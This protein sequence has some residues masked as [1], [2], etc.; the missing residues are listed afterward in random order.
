M[1]A[2]IG[3]DLTRPRIFFVLICAVLLVAQAAWADG[4]RLTEAQLLRLSPKADKS[5]AAAIVRH[6][7]ELLAAGI[8]GE[9]R[10]SHFLAQVLT[11]TAGLRRLDE[12]LSYSAERLVEVFRIPPDVAQGLA[13]RPRETANYL[14]GPRLGNLGR[15]TDDGWIYRGSGFIQLTGRYNFRMRGR[16]ARLPLEDQ[17]DLARQ[18]REGL[19]AAT[20]YWTA[21][22]INA[23]A[24]A[25]D[26]R[27]VR[28]RV[29][30]AL[31]GYEASLLWLR[32]SRAVLT[33]AGGRETALDSGQLV[34]AA[35]E[36][37][38]VLRELG[39]LPPS[40]TESVP[41]ERVE[42]AL[43][44]FQRSRSL[45]ETGAV[46][47]DTFYALTDPSEW[48]NRETRRAGL[49]ASPAGPS[50]EGISFDLASRQARAMAPGAGAGSAPSRP[51]PES[52][53]GSGDQRP[54]AQLAAAELAMLNEAAPF[55]APYEERTGA[56]GPRDVFVPFS[57]IGSDARVVIPITTSFPARA[58]VQIAF[59][60]APG[61]PLQGC[62]GA[63]VSRD[64][65]LTAGHCVHG[66]GR[67]EVWH[68]DF[69]V[70]PG[71]NAAMAPF[72]S[73]RATRLFSVRGWVE[74]ETSDE[75]R[76]HDLGAIRLDCGVGEQTGWFAVGLL[77]EATPP[78]PA[79]IYG[80]PCDKT[81]VGR[82]WRSDGAIE[83]LTPTK[84][85]YQN[86]TYGC[87]SG[88]PVLSG[89]ADRVVAVHTNGLHGSA[90]WSS[91]NAATRLSEEFI[92]GLTAFAQE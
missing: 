62:T 46:D 69:V 10:L 41:T 88:A 86:D 31:E 58:I 89:A 56:R 28:A 52:Q 63:M 6:W 65:V 59:R 54:A 40:S 81:P 91:H 70:V 90:P 45:A 83:I 7:D 14:Y 11:E 32:R 73:C 35:D 20:A 29:N 57:V 82:Q 23:A 13:R 3:R 92:Q 5:V 67:G 68:H 9:V 51:A 55:F 8:S 48:R 25:D 77:Q 34:A 80:Y 30:P 1:H 87:M 36:V 72:G 84:V 24:D 61:A 79:T 60:R 64:V 26:A 18:P 15:H 22:R 76:L 39:L 71:R 33:G 2:V 19:I 50:R 12:D 74:A 27:A 43:R 21:R 4:A 66:G 49:D 53:T 37:S 47:E 17:P 38:G 85:F 42:N 78:L 44:A 75:A 16:E